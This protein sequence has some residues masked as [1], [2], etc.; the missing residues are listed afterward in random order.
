MRVLIST[1]GSRG[2]VQ[3]MV[4]LAVSLQALGAETRLCV[5]P[6]P[7]FVDL[8]A[9]SHVPFAPAY[10]PVRPLVA[11]AHK[12][13][14]DIK[15]IGAEIIV[16][17]YDAL[18]EAADGCDAVVTE[19]LFPATAAARSVADRKN[20]PYVYAIP[21]PAFLPSHHHR[22][23]EFP[24]YPH[25]AGVTDNRAL[26]AHDVTVKNALF[27]EAYNA[28]R[29]SIG[30]P[31]VDNVRD[32]VFT[33]RPWLASDPVLSPWLPT[34]LREV[35]QTGAWILPD[36]RP[37]PADLETFLAA[38]APPVYVG[39]GSMPMQA[40]PDAARIAIEAVRAQGR[41]A[42]LARGWAD[43]AAIDDRDDCFVIGE[44]NQ[45]ALF[46]RV[47]AVVHHGG[48][49]TTTIAAQAGV[50]QLVVPQIGDQPYWAA[51]VADLGIGV[52]HGGPVPS[53]ATLCAGLD[54]VCA[55]A[56]SARAAAVARTIRTDGAARAAAMLVAML[57]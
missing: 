36:T 55:S 12:H 13:G 42:L 48:A 43:L 34:D 23:H 9:R 54:A 18:L 46:R 25:P 6:D 35:V 41:R 5:P 31:P 45:Q 56:M 26:W 49:G 27:G 20:I 15:Q 38:G 29:A 3:P 37:L 11:G 22:P 32:H 14:R 19:G 30:L 1:Y 39:F 17:Q 53:A 21:C 28:H 44:V 8:L 10:A 52:A 2:D 33:E 4:A 51:R 47:A 24:G 7:E 57:R 50:P 40:A 16:A